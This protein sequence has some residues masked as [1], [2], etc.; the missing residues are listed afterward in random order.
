V[1][2]VLGGGGQRLRSEVVE[3]RNL[4]AELGVNYRQLTDVGLWTVTA[5]TSP[6]GVESTLEAVR[7]NCARLARLRFR[8]TSWRRQGPTS[9]VRSA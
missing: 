1:T 9:V 3:T 8:T 2:A 4:A 7:A 6:D 5:T